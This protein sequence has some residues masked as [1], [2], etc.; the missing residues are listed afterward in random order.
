M[1]ELE[2]IMNIVLNRVFPIVFVHENTNRICNK[3]FKFFSSSLVGTADISK[4]FTVV[5]IERIITLKSY[6][7][8]SKPFVP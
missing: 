7:L 1:P 3:R 8:Y 2:I 5:N 4:F 6:K